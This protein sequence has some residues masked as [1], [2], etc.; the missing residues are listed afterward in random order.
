[1]SRLEHVV[2]VGAALREAAPAPAPAP[3]A[4]LFWTSD[5]EALAHQYVKQWWYFSRYNREK[6][7]D[8]A[9]VHLKYM[10]AMW[11]E[12]KEAMIAKKAMDIKNPFPDKAHVQSVTGKLVDELYKIPWG[13][14]DPPELK[15]IAKRLWSQ[16]KHRIRGEAS[17]FDARRESSVR[18]E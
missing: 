7:F 16:L 1:M 5:N 11:D 8:M 2:Q 10:N 14:W 18:I 4:G 6:Q 9:N 12:L 17:M 15:T 13:E 3:T